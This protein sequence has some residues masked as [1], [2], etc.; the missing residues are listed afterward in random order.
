MYE[1]TQK[2]NKMKNLQL[3]LAYQYIKMCVLIR[4][5][6]CESLVKMCGLFRPR[7]F[8]SGSRKN[9]ENLGLLFMNYIV[10]LNLLYHAE[11]RSKAFIYISVTCN[12][13][14]PF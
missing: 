11:A 9:S 7:I 4:H 6:L 13:R 10:I 3:Q 1:H 12:K 2:R 5:T 8:K 14:F